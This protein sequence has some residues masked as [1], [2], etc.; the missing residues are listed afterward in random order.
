MS[1]SAESLDF[2]LE[3]SSCFLSPPRQ[4]LNALTT[5]NVEK[6]KQILRSSRPVDINYV[7]EDPYNK[8]LLDIACGSSHCAS[9]VEVLIKSGAALDAVNAIHK[10]SPLHFA[11]E[12]SDLDTV[13][14]LV[15]SGA[16]V[17]VRDSFGN[18]PLHKAAELDKVDIVELLLQQPEIQ[19]GNRFI[20]GIY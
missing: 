19:V 5:R 15:N 12:Y 3:E 6:F 4:L 9:F 18:T 7:Y 1:E 14:L 10:K 17:N 8:S 16:N 13:E 2:D 20:F 11:V